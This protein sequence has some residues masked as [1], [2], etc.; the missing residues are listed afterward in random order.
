MTHLGWPPLDVFWKVLIPI[1]AFTV[2][3]ITT[4]AVKRN[5]M[6]VV[7]SVAT[8]TLAEVAKTVATLAVQIGAPGSLVIAPMVGT[9][10]K[11]FV[12]ALM[13]RTSEVER[14]LDA[15]VSEPL[16]AALGLLRDATNN[17]TSTPKEIESRDALLDAAHVSFVR[18]LALSGDSREDALFI[19]ALDSIALAERSGRSEVAADYLKKLEIELT[20]L[21]TRVE[22]IQKEAREWSDHVKALNRFL[23]RG[24]TVEDW[25]GRPV[26]YDVKIVFAKRSEKQAKKAKAEADAATFRFEMIENVV[27]LARASLKAQ[28][29]PA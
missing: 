2:G 13:S 14:K 22:A 6:P 8:K 28:V 3:A 26:G 29:K 5:P 12:D 18:A 4:R 17:S 9:I 24:D 11:D 10:S 16:K 15:L 7:K 21:R 20:D 23:G 27:T 25:T 1:A 19:R